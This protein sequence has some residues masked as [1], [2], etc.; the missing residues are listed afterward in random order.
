[1]LALLCTAVSKVASALQYNASGQ[2]W[3]LGRS[4]S[5]EPA[6]LKLGI[7]A[8]SSA[9]KVAFQSHRLLLSSSHFLVAAAY[10]PRGYIN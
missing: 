10:L 4:Q 8:R 7:A 1:M 9:E 3:A 6:H 2:L 5:A